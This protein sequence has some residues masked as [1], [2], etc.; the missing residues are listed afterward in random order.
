[1]EVSIQLVWIS[2]TRC[3]HWLPEAASITIGLSHFLLKLSVHCLS[4]E[5][6]SPAC[7]R[8]QRHTLHSNIINLLLAASSI[9]P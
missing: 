1:M 5:E 6:E 2:V 8:K 3:G 9:T 4:R 7:T